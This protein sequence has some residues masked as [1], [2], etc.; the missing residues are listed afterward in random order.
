MKVRMSAADEVG[1]KCE[2]E[3]ESHEGNEERGMKS[4]VLSACSSEEGVREDGPM[5]DH[6]Y[7]YGFRFPHP[8]KHQQQRQ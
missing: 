5:A 4:C 2:R 1:A 7:R 6:H 3:N 8:Q